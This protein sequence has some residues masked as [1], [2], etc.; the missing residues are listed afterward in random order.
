MKKRKYN[1]KTIIFG[2]E[3]I[4]QVSYLLFFERMNEIKNVITMALKE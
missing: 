2:V 4:Q 1:V 3:K